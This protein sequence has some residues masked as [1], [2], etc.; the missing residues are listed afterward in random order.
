MATNVGDS[1]AAQPFNELF[2]RLEAVRALQVNRADLTSTQ[3]TNLASTITGPVAVGNPTKGG[4]TGDIA[5]AKTAVALLAA[6]VDTIS[7]TFSSSIT[8][9]SVGELLR[10]SNI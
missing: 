4:D 8:I 6:N 10:A 7:D 1:V 3:R 2:E 5:K 9:P